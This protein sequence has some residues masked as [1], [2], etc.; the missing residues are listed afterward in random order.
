MSDR[1]DDGDRHGGGRQPA[2]RLVIAYDADGIRE[3]SRRRLE[4]VVPPSE[5][6]ETAERR[7][8][9][10]VEV[11]DADNELRY[12]RFLQDPRRANE[13][14][15]SDEA[16][17]HVGRAR[18]SGTFAVLVPYLFGGDIV[19]TDRRS[20]GGA[21]PMQDDEFARFPLDDDSNAAGR[22]ITP[23][24]TSD[25]NQVVGSEKIRDMGPDADRWTF[26]VLGEGYEEDELEAFASDADSLT[27]ALLNATPFDELSEGINVHRVDVASCESG[28]SQPGG[29]DDDDEVDTYFDGTFCTP[30]AAERT[31]VVDTGKVIAVLEQEV[32]MWDLGLVVVNSSERGGSGADLVPVTTVGS[33]SGLALHE[34]GHSAFALADEYDFFHGPDDDDFEDP[35]YSRY[36]GDEPEE[37]NITAANTRGDAKWSH[38]I[39]RGVDVPT[40]TKDD[41]EESD[42]GDSNPEPPGT[43]GLFEGAGYHRCGLYRPVFNCRMRQTHR[44]FCPVCEERIYETLAP[45]ITEAEGEIV[46][47]RVHDVGT[48][49]GPDRDHLDVE[50]VVRLD[51]APD[52]AFGF[53]LRDDEQEATRQRMLDTL[54]TAFEEGRE[55][56]IEYQATGAR[57]GELLA[58]EVLKES[59]T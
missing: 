13:K 7:A 29:C 18:D 53:Q 49:Y 10:G 4:R 26:V 15:E 21:R 2:L 24:P 12:V 11:R 9:F 45:F 25:C 58:V 36:E 23:E 51:T 44:D 57:N 19:V 33:S 17:T 42:W 8:G 40:T 39:P 48:G 16:L 31:L 32:P 41:C 54:R 47:L 28:V 34:I 46:F 38:L 22:S 55:V 43:V 6:L 5:P 27:D 3:V 56:G 52:R 35:D 14:V 30:E 50:V 59:N 1:E 20:A 37:P